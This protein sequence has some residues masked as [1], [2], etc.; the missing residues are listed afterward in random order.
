MPEQQ[1]S[2]PMPVIPA[3]IF[4]ANSLRFC[5]PVPNPRLHLT[6]NGGAVLPHLGGDKGKMGISPS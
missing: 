1:E 2:Q 5:I 4:R 6:E 3:T